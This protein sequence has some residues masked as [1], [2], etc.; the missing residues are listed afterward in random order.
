MLL[1]SPMDSGTDS[2]ESD[3]EQCSPLNSI[4]SDVPE[5]D[6][7]DVVEADQHAHQQSS[8]A[9]LHTSRRARRHRT[10]KTIAVSDSTASI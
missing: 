4:P 8:P 9:L 3:V 1:V 7:P 6:A 10:N 2:S 5:G